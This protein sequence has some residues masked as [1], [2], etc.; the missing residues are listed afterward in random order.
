MFKLN[1]RKE[2]AC[3]IALVLLASISAA[4]AQSNSTTA[5]VDE[6]AIVTDLLS[7]R[8]ELQAALDSMKSDQA[9]L[10]GLGLT[11]EVLTTAN[12]T[13]YQYKGADGKS[14]DKVMDPSGVLQSAKFDEDSKTLTTQYVNGKPSS[15]TY[16]DLKNYVGIRIDYTGECAC[17]IK[18]KD[19]K[20]GYVVTIENNPCTGVDGAIT[21][22]KDPGLPP[23]ASWCDVTGQFEVTQK[24]A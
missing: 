10:E 20:T 23:G 18:L 9:G 13:T 14:L 11:P 2:L 5:A 17:L 12:S 7:K 4:Y 8:A 19:Y 6:Q 16:V 3:F 21:L 22:S 1:V 15:E 24:V